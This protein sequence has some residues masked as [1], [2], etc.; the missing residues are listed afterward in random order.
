MP[1][2]EDAVVGGRILA[3]IEHDGSGSDDLE[4]LQLSMAVYSLQSR[5]DDLHSNGK[6]R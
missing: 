2:I 4:T 3:R 6:V 1:E 5:G